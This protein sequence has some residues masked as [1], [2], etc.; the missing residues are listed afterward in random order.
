MSWNPQWMEGRLR[1]ST[2]ACLASTWNPWPSKGSVSQTH[3]SQ[4]GGYFGLESSIFFPPEGLTVILNRYE[5]FKKVMQA[6]TNTAAVAKAGTRR[7]HQTPH[8][9]NVSFNI[10]FN[11]KSISQQCIWL[12]VVHL[13]NVVLTHILQGVKPFKPDSC[14]WSLAVFNSLRA[15]KEQIY[16]SNSKQ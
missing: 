11:T 6:K 14:S 7:W 10:I 13:I 16:P 9:V 4:E 8:C 1:P 2:Y 5:E 15:R 12:C 3:H